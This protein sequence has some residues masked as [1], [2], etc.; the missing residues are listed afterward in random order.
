MAS[1]GGGSGGAALGKAGSAAS[2]LVGGQR[3]RCRGGTYR[4]PA[5]R[6]PAAGQHQLGFRAS[7]WA[8]DSF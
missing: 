5:L 2:M 3:A 1:A 8:V 7:Y 4:V 6:R